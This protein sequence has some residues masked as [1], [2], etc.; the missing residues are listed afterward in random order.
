MVTMYFNLVC[1]HVLV[2]IASQPYQKSLIRHEN[3]MR[4]L[5]GM[6]LTVPACEQN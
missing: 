5:R 1:S 3:S 6:V 4:Q 2:G